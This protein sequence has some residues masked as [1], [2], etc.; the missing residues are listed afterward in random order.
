MVL[1]ILFGFVAA[2]LIAFEASWELTLLF[3]LAFPIVGSFS[4]IQTR[5]S[6]G[7]IQ[8][9]KAKLE[10]SGSSVVDSVTNMRTVVGLGV[11]D[12]FYSNYTKL[13]QGPF[14]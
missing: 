1:Q 10:A 5:L 2:V 4:F 8:K 11:E 13:L 9:N 12:R 14:E 7:L 3:L 6:V